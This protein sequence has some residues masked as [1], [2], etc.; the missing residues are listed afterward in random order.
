MP[1]VRGVVIALVYLRTGNLLLVVGLHALVNAPMLLVEPPGAWL[2]PAAVFAAM[3]LA[4][5]APA[6]PPSRLC[7]AR[8]SRVAPRGAFRL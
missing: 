5:V 7:L 3:L 6:R 2:A 4:I 1:L 8:H